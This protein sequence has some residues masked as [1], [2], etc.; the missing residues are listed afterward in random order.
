M[1][2]DNRSSGMALER[3]AKEAASLGVDG[4]IYPE[5]CWR[6]R[7]RVAAAQAGVA[8]IFLAAPTSGAERIKHMGQITKG[9]L[10]YVSVTGITGARTELPPDLVTALKEVRALVKGPLAVGRHLHPGAGEVAGPVRG[11]HRG[12]QRYRPAGG[13]AEGERINQRSGRFY[14]GPEGALTVGLR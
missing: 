13:K 10:Y 11:R 12:G 4:F 8:S 1:G 14:R 7:L 9:F 5:C 3:T 2:D 6:R